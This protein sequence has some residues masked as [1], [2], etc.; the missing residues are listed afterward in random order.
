MNRD[1]SPLSGACVPFSTPRENTRSAFFFF[2]FI[3]EIQS[4]ELTQVHVVLKMNTGNKE[5]T[6]TQITLFFTI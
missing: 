3:F 1:K 6:Q 2:F 5:V 4:E